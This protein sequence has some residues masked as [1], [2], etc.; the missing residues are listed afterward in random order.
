MLYLVDELKVNLYEIT[1][2][3]LKEVQ[4]I[5]NEFDKIVSKGLYD[6]SNCLTIKHVI[7]LITDVP[8]VEKIGYHMPKEHKQIEDQVKIMLENGVIEELNSPYAFNIV[9]IG[10]KN[11]IKEGMDRLYVNY[12]SLNKITISDRYLL[13][14][15]NKTCSQF[16]E[17]RQF[18]TL[19]LTL[20]Y[21][22]V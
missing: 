8:V 2:T 1:A 13:L 22:Q 19:D 20:T 7:R 21:W 6:I 14:N 9:I 15:I 12:E 16:W 4:Q 11:G 10:K 3:Y 18:T 5:L 17:N